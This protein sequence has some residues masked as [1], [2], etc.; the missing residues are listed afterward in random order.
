MQ[1]GS[2]LSHIC[3]GNRVLILFHTQIKLSVKVH[4]WFW[5]GIY[6]NY[7]K[8][9]I[10]SQLLRFSIN[11]CHGNSWLCDSKMLNLINSGILL[12]WFWS[13]MIGRWNIKMQRGLCIMG[14]SWVTHVM[15][16]ACYETKILPIYNWKMPKTC[17]FRVI[18]GCLIRK[19]AAISSY[20]SC[21]Y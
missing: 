14:G 3:H 12:K 11:G 8:I 7:N 16:T 4:A 9:H 19:D 5:F 13:N 15:E 21:I 6:L 20:T 17:C 1:F 18:Q 2:I 10:L